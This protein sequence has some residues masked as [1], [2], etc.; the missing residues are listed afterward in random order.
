M[1]EITEVIYKKWW[2]CDK[3]ID[4]YLCLPLVALS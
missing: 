3:C 1:A 2:S 4:D